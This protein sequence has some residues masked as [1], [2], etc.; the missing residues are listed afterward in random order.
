MRKRAGSA[1]EARRGASEAAEMAR[2]TPQRAAGRQRHRA[3]LLRHGRRRLSAARGRGLRRPPSRPAPAS[4]AAAGPAQPRG[5]SRPRPGWPVARRVA[6]QRPEDQ[7]SVRRPARPRA[8]IQAETVE[9]GARSRSLIYYLLALRFVSRA[10]VCATPC[11]L[12][13]WHIAF[14]N[15]LMLLFIVHCV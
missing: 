3:R 13:C 15:D 6:G 4:A 11:C 8:G 2:G 7:G 1:K 14:L 12:Y 9:T 5:R 10:P